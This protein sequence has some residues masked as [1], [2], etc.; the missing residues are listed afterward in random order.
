MTVS[1]WENMNRD[2]SDYFCL[3]NLWD[4]VYLLNYTTIQTAIRLTMVCSSTYGLCVR[5]MIPNK[6]A[7]RKVKYAWSMIHIATVP[8][9]QKSPHHFYDKK[10]NNKTLKSCQGNITSPPSCWNPAGMTLAAQGAVSDRSVANGNTWNSPKRATS[11]NLKLEL[12]STKK[13]T[14][15]V[16]PKEKPKVI[17]LMRPVL[18]GVLSSLTFVLCQPSWTPAHARVQ[19]SLYPVGVWR[20]GC[21]SMEALCAD[22]EVMPQRSRR[23]REPLLTLTTAGWRR[24]GRQ[25][26]YRNKIMLYNRWLVGSKGQG[27]SGF[28]Y[29]VQEMTS[30]SERRCDYIL[31]FQF[32]STIIYQSLECVSQVCWGPNLVSG[33]SFMSHVT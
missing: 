9:R 1:R 3:T 7:H 22:L 15:M 2:R 4:S 20:W 24:E 11:I 16:N 13:R 8:T 5:K 10:N 31:R 27:G 17:N 25:H 14:E 30:R 19:L 26:G 33:P 28:H 29:G 18:Q 23:K 12:F 21:C 32:K 6:K